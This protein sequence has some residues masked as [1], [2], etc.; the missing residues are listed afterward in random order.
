MTKV[1]SIIN[2]K[3][4]VAKTTTT[5][6]IAEM[7]SAAFNGN[8]LVIDLDPQGAATVMLC[9]V[10]RAVRLI[11]EKTT[12]LELLRSRKG[13]AADRFVEENV[14]DISLPTGIKLDLIPSNPDLV[15]YSEGTFS[16]KG[17]GGPNAGRRPPIWSPSLRRG[18]KRVP[19]NG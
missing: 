17:I 2:L 6:T 10:D 8:V 3:G 1:I 16:S 18:A 12:L 4:G 9:G 5:V 7:L 19:G 14:S 11:N 15:E 13:D